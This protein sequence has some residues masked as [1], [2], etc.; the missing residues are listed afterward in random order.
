MDGKVDHMQTGLVQLIDHES[1]HGITMLGDHADA[2]PLAEALHEILFGP[3][4]LEAGRLNAQNVAHVAA[5]HP[6]NVN[7]E[8][9]LMSRH[10]GLLP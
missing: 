6:T 4:K 1:H 5:N 8:I 2:V 10:Q 9:R 3:R 7:G